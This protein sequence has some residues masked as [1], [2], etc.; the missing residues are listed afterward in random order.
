M[1]RSHE[2]I[3]ALESEIGAW[4]KR[5]PYSLIK[6][7]NP[8]CT[9]Y[10]LFAYVNETPPFQ[11]WSLIAADCL[12]NLASALD[13]LVYAIACHEARGISDKVAGKLA[14]PITDNPNKWDEAIDRG[15]L[16]GISDVVRAEILKVQPYNRPHPALPPLLAILRDLNNINK[17]RLLWL[18]YGAPSFANLGFYGSD[19]AHWTHYIH[20]GEI[21]DG[22]EIFAH[23][24]DRPAPN[25]EWDQTILDLIVAIWHGKRSPTDP[26]GSDRNE[27][28]SV[29]KD[30][31]DDVRKVVYQVA[32]VVK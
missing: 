7:R 11:R 10:S 31:G 17:H 6:E 28:I 32:G 24:A 12:G 1:A 2:H 20:H 3:Q 21:K 30:I 8:D 9:R 13:H 4:L 27:V 16:E 15:R 18:V 25:M 26:E 14:F 5:K 22:T 23:I 29:L 19:E